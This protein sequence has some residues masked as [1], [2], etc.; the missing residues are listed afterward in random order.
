MVANL[1]TA[2]I[3]CRILTLN[4]VGTAVNY[5]SIYIRLAPGLKVIRHFSVVIYESEKYAL[6]YVPGMPFQ[7]NLMFVGKTSS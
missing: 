5:C 2:V 3:Y 4:N 6:N 1:N 7:P